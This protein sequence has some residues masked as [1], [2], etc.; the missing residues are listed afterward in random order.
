MHGMPGSTAI[1]AVL[2]STIS[3]SS[4]A[5][6]PRRSCTGSPASTRT[7]AKCSTK[8]SASAFMS[9]PSSASPL[10]PCSMRWFAAA[11]QFD[12]TTSTAAILGPPVRHHTTGD[13]LVGEKIQEP[14]CCDRAP[15]ADT[16]CDE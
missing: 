12:I 3:S 5:A 16:P 8:W 1:T 2:R 7:C 14:W 4:T 6:R 10:A 15:R 11:N 9:S 13:G